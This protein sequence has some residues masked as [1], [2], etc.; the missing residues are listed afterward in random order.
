MIAQIIMVVLLS[1]NLLLAANQHGKPKTGVNSFWT[2]LVA[3]LIHV[4]ILY[5]GGFFKVWMP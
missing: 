5:F 1:S 2:N 3:A 4:V